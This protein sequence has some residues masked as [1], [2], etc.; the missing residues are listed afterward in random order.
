MRDIVFDAKMFK[1][2]VEKS[3]I[4]AF[5]TD[6]KGN[7]NDYWYNIFDQKE[8][9]FVSSVDEETTSFPTITIEVISTNS[10]RY[11]RTSSQN[12][13]YSGVDIEIN[14]YV[15]DTQAM[16][17]DDLGLFVGQHIERTLQ[18]KLGLTVNSNQAVAS[19]Q[20]NLYRRVIRLDGIVNNKQYTVYNT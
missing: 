6:L 20:K 19:P 13:L 18:E 16:R 4:Y 11:L 3:L 9:L 10:V 15:V 14:L 2:A 8:M 17:R 5:Q 1:E 12:Q 7:K